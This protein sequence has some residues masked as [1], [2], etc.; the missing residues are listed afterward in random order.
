MDIKTL[1]DDFRK[2]L[3]GGKVMLTRG[4]SSKGQKAINE[5]LYRVKTFDNFTTD[6]DPYNEHD[7]G[8]FL[9]DG[10]KIMWKI[11]YYDKDLRYFS[12]DPE[13]VSK[14]IRVMTIMLVEE[15]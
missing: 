8:S 3:L 15:Y 1:N 5:I 2:S 14:T 4:I 13:D 9:Y 10:Q 6:N 11:D 12:E 7:Y